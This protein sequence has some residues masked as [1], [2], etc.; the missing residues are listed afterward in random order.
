VTSLGDDGKLTTTFPD[1]TK[2]VV[3][4]AT[5]QAVTTDPD[6][7][8]TTENL[9]SLGDLNTGN[10]GLGNLDGLETPTGGQTGL[11]DGDFATM[12][13]DGGSTS[14]DPESG[15]LTSTGPDG[16]V[17][18]TDL[19]HGARVNNPD[20]STTFL[21]DGQLTTT[22]PDGSKQ[23]INPDTGV[24]TVTDAQ[25]R[26]ETVDLKDLNTSIPTNSSGIFD[27][28]GGLGDLD[29]LN[30]SG[31]GTTS[32]D[33]PLSELGLG[34]GQITAGASGGGIPGASLDGLTTGQVAPLSDSVSAGAGTPLAAAGGAGGAPGAPGTPGTPGMPM[35]GGMGGMGAGGDKGNGERV[36]SVLVDAAEESERRT[37]RRRSPWNRQEDSDTF[38][39]PASRVTTT[40]GDSP[41]EPAE[42]GRRVTTS[43]DYLEEDADVWGTEEGGTPSV[44]GR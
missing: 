4:P 32:R 36:R 12:F 15:M 18:E 24:A 10:N 14:F 23:V 8:V 19:T 30:G 6:G 26:T 42:P 25:G 5:G 35:G 20:G 40:G 29:G 39:S 16:S 43:A 28:L 44:I 3:D 11:V 38:L 1:G 34:G 27:D 31:G 21:D 41:E 22:F 9:G 13:A 33:V 37:R 2:Q 17:V 7:T